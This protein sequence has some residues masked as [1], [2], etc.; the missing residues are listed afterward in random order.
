VTKGITRGRAAVASQDVRQR[1]D[2]GAKNGLNRATLDAQKVQKIN[3]LAISDLLATD[4]KVRSS[5]LFGRAISSNRLWELSEIPGLLRPAGIVTSLEELWR[6]WWSGSQ[7]GEEVQ[8]P[9]LPV[10][11]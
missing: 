6:L 8:L 5:N 10:P 11:A 4:Q 7:R 3:D 1:A 9:R 2:F